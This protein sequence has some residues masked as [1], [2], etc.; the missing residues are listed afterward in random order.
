MRPKVRLLDLTF[1]RFINEIQNVILFSFNF[2]CLRITENHA[3]KE[4]QIIGGNEKQ[5]W[6][7]NYSSGGCFLRDDVLRPAVESLHHQP[8][9]G[10]Y[11][12]ALSEGQVFGA[13]LVDQEVALALVQDTF[14]N[15]E[16]EFQSSFEYSIEKKRI[17][18]LSVPT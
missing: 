9:V 11:F 8:H 10:Y 17:E 3:R 13:R 7:S 15:T 16:Y 12:A 2:S 4:K 5:K 6:L 18:T 1:T 14:N